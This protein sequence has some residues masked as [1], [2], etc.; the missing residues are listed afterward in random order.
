[1]ELAG[2][3]ALVTG[4][5]SGIGEAVSRSLAGRGC[6]LLI[7]GRDTDRLDRLATEVGPR[8]G[9]DVVIL[10]CD[11]SELEQVRSLARRLAGQPAPDLVVHN[12]GIGLAS[13][14]WHTTDGE[15][16]RL[17]AVNARAPM[18]LNAQLMPR[19]RERGSGRLIFITSIVAYLGAPEESG[20]AASKAAMMS[21]A[22]SLRSE[23]AGS[24]VGV[25]TVAPGVV[26][27]AFFDRRGTGYQRRFPEPITADRVAST[28][29][30]AIDRGRAEVIVPGWLRLP[31]IVHAVAPQLYARLADRW[32]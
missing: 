32:S 7:T 6:R 11:L 2:R 16:D 17:W 10:P 12:A 18:L 21:Y 8:A 27:T 13:P 1:M 23:L 29:L 24:G 3:L 19:M 22:T 14:A 28:V 4:A 5:S 15:L 30:R 20:Y 26:R 9:G 25:T 31:V